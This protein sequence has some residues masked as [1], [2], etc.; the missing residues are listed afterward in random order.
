MSGVAVGL[1][2]SA[3]VLIVA[4]AVLVVALLLVSARRRP[5]AAREQ[6]VEA[7]A[8]ARHPA[9]ADPAPLVVAL[10]ARNAG[11]ADERDDARRQLAALR[12]AH[13]AQRARLRRASE[14]IDR[15]IS[16]RP[17]GANGDLSEAE[18][19]AAVLREAEGLLVA[20]AAA[21]AAGPP[22]TS[23][24][25]SPGSGVGGGLAASPRPRGAHDGAFS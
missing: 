14:L 1:A 6:A 3:L 23:L 20:A 13:Q 15:A 5:D 17:R 12:M 24:V 22:P 4:A 9:A 19:L 18:R 16:A 10:L 2:G 25:A 11:L 8:S 21:G 7:P